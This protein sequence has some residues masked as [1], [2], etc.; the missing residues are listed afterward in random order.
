MGNITKVP[1]GPLIKKTGKFKGSTLKN[2]GPVQ[3][4]VTDK[5]SVKKVDANKIMKMNKEISAREYSNKRKDADYKKALGQKAVTSSRQQD[6]DYLFK[7]ILEQDSISKAAGKEAEKIKKTYRKEIKKPTM[8]TGGPIKK[9]QGGDTLTVKKSKVD[10]FYKNLEKQPSKNSDFK[11]FYKGEKSKIKDDGFYKVPKVKS[12]GLKAGGMIKRAD[13]S[14]SRRGL[15][16]N[17]RAN[18]G[19]GKKP[20]A[21]MLK[22]ERKIKAKTK[23]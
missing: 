15:W 3:K 10:G 22:Q 6:L 23:K 1:N 21:A 13:G 2:G 4:V 7:D 11:N 5:T 18:K 19:S 8:K 20:T 17:I 12:T 14:M 9:A 16:D